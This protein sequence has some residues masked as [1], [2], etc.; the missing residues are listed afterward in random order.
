M[1]KGSSGLFPNTTGS[2]ISYFGK[3]LLQSLDEPTAK[4][5]YHIKATQDNY[6]GTVIPRSFEIDVPQFYETPV[7]KMWTHGNATEHM[8]E[9]IMSIKENPRLKGSNPNLYSQFVLYDYYKSLG[10]AVRKGINYKKTVRV[11]NWV[12]AFA[13]AR[14][15]QKYPVVKHALFTG[16]KK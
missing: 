5:W 7:G 4:V 1:S 12:F 11:G 10:E 8:F 2:D 13:P 9:A 15:S 16:F 6:R 3:Q 14:N